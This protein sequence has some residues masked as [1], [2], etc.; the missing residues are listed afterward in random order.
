MTWSE[1]GTAITLGY[2]GVGDVLRQPLSGVQPCQC[3]KARIQRNHITC[4][5][6]VRTFIKKTARL[7]GKTT[8]KLKSE[9]LSDYLK[10][11][12]KYPAIRLTLV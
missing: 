9:L 7:M 6:L 3:R 11:K 2:W 10:K 1:Q 12:L 4:A 5:I 8:A